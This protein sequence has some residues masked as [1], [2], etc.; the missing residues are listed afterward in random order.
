MQCPALPCLALHYVKQRYFTLNYITLHYV[1]LRYI[2]LH[3]HAYVCI[4]HIAYMYIIHY[5]TYNKYTGAYTCT[6]EYTYHISYIIYH[7]SHIIY[8]ISYI[9]SDIISYHYTYTYTICL[10]RACSLMIHASKPGPSLQFHAG[11]L[12][13]DQSCS[14]LAESESRQ[15]GQLGQSVHWRSRSCWFAHGCTDTHEHGSNHGMKGR[16]VRC[17]FTNVCDLLR[18]ADKL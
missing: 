4:P 12:G 3:T 15:F 18:Q 11:D 10:C 1:A 13:K 8:H 17:H 7:I 2:A 6:Y 14:I 5:C 9:I 16:I